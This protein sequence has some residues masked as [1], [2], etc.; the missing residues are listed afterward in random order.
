MES[1][2]PFAFMGLLVYM[3]NLQGNNTIMLGNK[4]TIKGYIGMH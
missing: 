4:I 1:V 3:A 2:N